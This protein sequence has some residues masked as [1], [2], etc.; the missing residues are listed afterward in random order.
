M[1]FIGRAV[2]KRIA[3]ALDDAAQTPEG[4]AATERG[5]RRRALVQTAHEIAES[6]VDDDAAC[7]ELCAR[8]PRDPEAVRD[9]IEHLAALR[10]SYVDDRAFRLLTAAVDDTPIRPIDPGVREQFLAEA[11]LGR[12]SLND[13]FAH[14]VSLE[15]R[16]QDLVERRS[17]HPAVRRSGFSVGRSEPELVGPLA[18]SV[19]A[20]VNTDLARG[21]VVEYLAVTRDGLERDQDPTPF[22][23]RKRRTFTGTF[24]VFDKNQPRAQ[25]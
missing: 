6:G 16:L 12:M 2:G 17:G 9:A 20:V 24:R 11:L 8:L 1:R 3:K 5:A 7:A 10:T 22:F 21:V 4:K 25:N 18:D 23:E 15:P 19:Y 14:L 13:A